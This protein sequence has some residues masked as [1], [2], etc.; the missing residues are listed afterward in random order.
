MSIDGETGNDNK[1]RHGSNALPRALRRHHK[2]RMKAKAKFVAKRIWGRGSLELSSDEV[3]VQAT[4]NADH[5]AA[6]SCEMCR[7]PR[8]SRWR[9]AKGKT[10]KEL[11][12][13]KDLRDSVG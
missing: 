5:L 8:R 1:S 3:V 4:K 9:R 7:N 11:Q 12:A 2:Y 13:A 10:R 6:C